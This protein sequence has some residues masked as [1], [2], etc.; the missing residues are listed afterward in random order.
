[1]HRPGRGF[2]IVEL[3]IVIVV[4]AILAA[5]TIAVYNGIQQRAKTSVVTNAVQLWEQTIRR[6]IVEG[7]TFSEYGSSCL[8]SEGDFPAKDGFAEGVCVNLNG[9][10]AMQY[11]AL[12][13]QGWPNAVTKPNGSI[14]ITTLNSPDFKLKARGIWIE[15]IDPSQKLLYISWVPQNAGKCGQGT[16]V[17]DGENDVSGSYCTKEIRY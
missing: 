17:V 8:G 7:Y 5:I 4:I 15:L 11:D 12:T 14:V 1:M 10:A 2:T 13:L 16:V 3:L 6:A 9:Y